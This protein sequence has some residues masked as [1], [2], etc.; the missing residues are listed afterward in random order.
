MRLSRTLRFAPLLFTHKLTGVGLLLTRR[1]N[2][3]CD[4]CQ[5]IRSGAPTTLTPSQWNRI[6]DRF[7]QH[8][9]RHFVLTGGEPLLYDGVD[10]VI[11]HASRKALVSLITNGTLLTPETL[12]RLAGLDFLTISFDTLSR[13][14]PGAKNRLP[15][16]RDMVREAADRS[17]FSISTITTITRRNLRE[18]PAIIEWVLA[19]GFTAMVSVIHAGKTGNV[20]THEFRRPLGH[21][22]A[23][24][25]EDRALVRETT[26][27]LLALKDRY[28]NFAES[29]EFIRGIPDFLEGRFQMPC[30]AGDAYMEVNNDGTIMACHDTAPSDVSALTFTDYREMQR[31]VREKIPPNCTCYYNCSY[32]Y[33]LLRDHPLRHTLRLVRQRLADR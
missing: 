17:G 22:N 5:V 7:V 18:A 13:D 30:H 19:A 2:L 12:E 4:Y 20:S 14:L 26:S 27:R 10:E 28:P 11:R 31:R 6:I 15:D 21:Q 23:I 1:C 3:A 25:E 29:R 33:A 32:N 16:I 24:P 9:H 8:R